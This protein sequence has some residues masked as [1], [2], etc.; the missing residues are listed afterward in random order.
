[1]S[2]VGK[3]AQNSNTADVSYIQRYYAKTAERPN[4]PPDRKAVYR[5]VKVTGQCAGQD[6]DLLVQAIM[7]HQ[8]FLKKPSA[9]GKVSV[10][11][12]NSRTFEEASL[13]IAWAR[14]WPQCFP[15]IGH[16]FTKFL[17]AQVV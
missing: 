14:D 10:A 7:L 11:V 9:D 5:N 6:N 1:M 2:S 15:T 17:G 4:T 16:R 13:C 12:G 3:A 8:R